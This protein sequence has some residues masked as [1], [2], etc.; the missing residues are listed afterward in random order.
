MTYET[1]TEIG[2]YRI[3]TE[4]LNKHGKQ[5]FVEFGMTADHTSTR[6]DHSIERAL[7]NEDND[8]NNYSNLERGYA[9]RNYR[10]KGLCD[11][12]PDSVLKLVN[13]AFDCNFTEIFIDNF[14]L[15]CDGVMCES[16]K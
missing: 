5:F 14:D 3:R 13:K 7:A 16:P 10:S 15:S 9:L 6:C 8:K 1:E 2:N 4:F 11:Y 12:T